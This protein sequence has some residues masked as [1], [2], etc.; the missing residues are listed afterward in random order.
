MSYSMDILK[1]PAVQKSEEWRILAFVNEKLW[2]GVVVFCSLKIKKNFFLVK[3]Q[4]W[5]VKRQNWGEKEKTG[6]HNQK[7]IFRAI[8]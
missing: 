1:I 3:R 5:I 4:N 8:N 7:L 6:Q 2:C